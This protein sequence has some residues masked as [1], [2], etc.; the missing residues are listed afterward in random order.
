MIGT[1]RLTAL[2]AAVAA[3]G[4]G[5]SRLHA[6]ATTGSIGGRVTGP[7]GQPLDGVQVQVTNTATG[8]S[9]GAITRGDGRFVVLGLEPGSGYRVTARRIGFAPRVVPNLT[10]TLGGT[11]PVQLALESQAV[12]LQEV[13]VT[14]AAT[15]NG[16]IAPTRT[17]TA[18][19]ITDT[20][21]RK[22]PTL[23]RNFTDFVQLTP[24]VS[25]SGPGLSGGG[26]NN[27]YN[28]VQID[29]ANAR[30]IF[31]LGSTGQP[32][33]Q[34]NGKSIGIESVKEYQVQLAPFDVRIGNFAGVSIN[35]IT[36]SGTNTFTGSAYAFTRDQRLQRDQPYLAD[37]R[38]TQYGF[39]L[40][41]PILRNRAFFF[42]NPEFQARRTPSGG[43]FLGAAGSRVTQPQLDRF[44]QLLTAAGLRDLGSAGLVQNQNPLDN[45][46]AR[47]DVALPYN[48]TLVLRNNIINADQD[49]FSR[50]TVGATPGFGLS[51]NAY[52]FISRTQQPVAQLRTNFGNGAFNELIVAYQR[53]RDKRATPGVL[54]PQ[55]QATVPQVANLVAG[56]DAPS[57]A[58]QLDQDVFELTENFTFPVGS[59]HRVTVGTQNQFY[60][61]RN[62]FGNAAVGNWQFANLDSLAN[63][64]PQQYTIGVPIVGDGAVRIRAA[65]YSGYLQDEW[66][67]TDRLTITAGVRFDVPR[68][69]SRPPQNPATDLVTGLGINTSEFPSGN[70]QWAP[71]LG[72]NWNV[73]GD[74][75]NQLRGGAGLFTGQPAFVWLANSF[76]NSG[77]VSGFGTLTCL[78]SNAPRFTAANV[79]TPPQACNDGTTARGGSEVNFVDGDARFPQTARFNLGYDRDLGGG[80]VLTVE[81]LFTRTLDNLFYANYALSD[82]LFNAGARGLDGRVV[83]GLQP[84]APRLRVS[85]R[86][87]VLGATNQSRDYSYNLTGRLEK[88]FT[89]DFGGSVAYTFSQARDVVSLTSST[90]GSQWRFGRVYA[91]SQF[92][93]ALTRSVFET[94][95][96]VVANGSYTV[97]RTRTS[98]SAIYVGQSGFR[99]T[100]VS[101]GDLNGDGVGAGTTQNDPIYVPTGLNDT[102]APVF[103]P[104]TLNGVQYSA[105]EQAA[106]FDRLIQST[107]CLRN[108]R[109]RILE[110][111]TCQA[112]WTNQLDLSVEQPVA[113][114]RGQSLTVRLDAINFGNFINRDFGR[115][116]SG[117]TQQITYT[118]IG[119]G[120]P[121]T[122]ATG[123][124][125]TLLNSVPR[126]NFDP[127]FT[128]FNYDNVVSNYTFQLGV[129]YAF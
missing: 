108:S 64:S 98:L 36:R 17:G 79:A 60:R 7:G 69:S 53:T 52:R 22:L 25:S 6:Q 118:Q 10:V 14:A 125:Q 49:I 104:F 129:R 28:N 100:F 5:A 46:F 42:V 19:T 103:V 54:Q 94:P 61:F 82:S 45:V 20:L 109:G 56:T 16:L 97:P 106:G 67:A 96:R 57:Q 33:G 70:V 18:T 117:I 110:R 127:N 114:V 66:T 32:G 119:I 81:G 27:R 41:G 102:R 43:F 59:A 126:A 50:G 1:R 71:R 68:F 111:N 35:A 24:Q 58:N 73:T 39:S 31:G 124:G 101:S 55:V 29:G 85:T 88:R 90:A 44:T 77:G 122:G 8:R 116:A 48:T 123:A 121:G 115:Q 78:T 65:S 21:I 80:V 34:A 99:Y 23:N 3:V 120:A 13:A 92:D 74:R 87:L 89:R 12:Q 113:R 93:Q 83:Y 107:P 91:G 47:L 128:K 26:V 72:F 51:S 30:D 84:L 15:G 63:G 76:Q 105:G 11:T 62:L 38:Q 40:G 9:S 95:H 112:P 75:K 37:F 86:N 2:A 4:G